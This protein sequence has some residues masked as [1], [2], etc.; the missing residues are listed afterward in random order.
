MV[1]AV[2]DD[3][4]APRTA[5]GRPLMA[6]VR[7]RLLVAVLLANAIGAG[8]VISFAVLVLPRPAGVVD[9]GV[10]ELN[11]TAAVV[12]PL[13]ALAVGAWW[14][15][16]RVEHGP[17]GLGAWLPDDRL[18]EPAQRRRALR[19][20]ARLMV[21]QAVLW[22]VA[23]VGFVLL[24]VHASGLL[25]LGV[26]LTVALGGVTTSTAAYLQTE[27]V[28][29]PVT[30]RAMAAG[31][32]E[33][34]GRLPRLAR[35]WLLSWALGTG[36]PVLG[37]MLV[38]IVVLTPVDVSSTTLAVTIVA[39]CAIG[40]VFG[41]TVSVLAAYATVV[42]IVA[43]QRGVDRVRAGDYDARVGVWDTTEVGVLQAGFNDMVGGLRDRERI[44]DLFGRQVGED[45][46]RE[47]MAA[48]VRLGGERREVAV[49]FV[50]LV[51]STT[52]ASDREPEEVVE[53]LNRFFAEVVDAVEEAG[54]SINK[55]EGDAALAVFGAP[56]EMDDAAGSALRCA[57]SLDARLRSE[58]AELRAGIGVAAG[59]AVAGNIGA[60]QRYEYTV[61]GDPVNE[62]A[63]LTD[64]AKERDGRILASST[65]VELAAGEEP[66]AWEVVDEVVL[67]GRPEAT[68][69]AT[70]RADHRVR[71]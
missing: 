17:D 30:E 28:M 63:R 15:R 33:P 54:G 27:I 21:V 32:E 1:T 6:R 50:D 42:P 18:P 52:L 43:I 37:L 56:L 29:R 12:Y 38:G 48:D 7:R 22:G 66:A 14:G 55:F 9:A 5:S 47:A 13:L 40:L 4:P 31:V 2:A 20:P 69:V 60:E 16:R 67:R 11:A 34:N 26:G 59:A 36:V 58:V 70:P 53:L 49:L 57:R 39:L 46:A 3:P 62:A 8:V 44:R 41:A 71:S 24:N 64:L 10:L 45:V 51:G 23:V 61:I 25:A 19:A 65:V 68:R 35:R